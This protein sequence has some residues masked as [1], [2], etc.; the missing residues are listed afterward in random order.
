ML[1]TS[2]DFVEVSILV[3]DVGSVNSILDVEDLVDVFIT[4]PAVLDLGGS[5]GLQVDLV[6]LNRLEVFDVRS[7]ITGCKIVLLV[8]GVAKSR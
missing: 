1:S 2:S 7:R 5:L 3:G 4:S 8:W 6:Q